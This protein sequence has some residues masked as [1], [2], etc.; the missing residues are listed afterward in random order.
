[1]RSCWGFSVIQ[2]AENARQ[3]AAIV[4]YRISYDIAYFMFT[5]CFNNVYPM[6]CS[7]FFFN[8]SYFH[9]ILFYRKSYRNRHR[10][11]VNFLFYC[12][13]RKIDLQYICYLRIYI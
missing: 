12:T 1:M 11:I 3:S 8:F 4:V 2:G 10:L 13:L 7:G 6:W 9:L 5:H